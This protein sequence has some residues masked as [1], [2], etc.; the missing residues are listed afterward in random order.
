MAAIIFV[1]LAV[2]GGTQLYDWVAA[3]FNPEVHNSLFHIKG[4]TKATYM[5]WIRFALMNA[6][7][8]GG[9]FVLRH[10]IVGLSL[11]QDTDG[12][13]IKDKQTPNA[14]IYLVLFGIGFTFYVW[15]I[16]LSLHVNWFSTMWGV[17]LYQR[18]AGLLGGHHVDRI[19]PAQE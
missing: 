15:D 1:V 10:R 13:C 14:I 9:W 11:K 18:G 4:G 12:Q 2:Y 5:H 6:L 7:F 3:S 19:G 17:L 8:F 16:L